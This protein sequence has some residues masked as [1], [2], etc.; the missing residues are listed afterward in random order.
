M[1]H[2]QNLTPSD[3]S[4]YSFKA[5]VNRHG[6]HGPE[7]HLSQSQAVGRLTLSDRNIIIL[8][9]RLLYRRNALVHHHL[10]IYDHTGPAW[11]LGKGW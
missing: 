11:K 9:K 1:G 8:S 2:G 6:R 4:P 7:L 10:L 3:H 5:F